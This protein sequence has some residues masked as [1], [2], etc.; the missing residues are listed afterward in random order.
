[1]REKAYLHFLI[2]E[3]RRSKEAAN[4]NLYFFEHQS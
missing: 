2:K 3:R 4:F 1:M